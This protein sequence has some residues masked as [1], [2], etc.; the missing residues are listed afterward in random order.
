MRRGRTSKTINEMYFTIRLHISKIKREVK[1]VL[2]D[3]EAEFDFL[4]F[5]RGLC[6]FLF[7]VCNVPAGFS[8]RD[9]R[10]SRHAVG[11]RV[12]R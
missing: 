8:R 5:L 7:F 6:L 2:V 1:F 4:G 3:L 11:A 10:S 9:Q 12:S